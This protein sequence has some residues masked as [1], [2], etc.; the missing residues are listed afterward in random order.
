MDIKKFFRTIKT[1]IHLDDKLKSIDKENNK[2]QNNRYDIDKPQADI[3][4]ENNYCFL[5]KHLKPAICSI[6]GKL[7]DSFIHQ[8]FGLQDKPSEQSILIQCG[9]IF[10]KFNNK[11]ITLSPNVENLIE[12]SNYVSIDGKKRQVDHLFKTDNNIIWYL[13]SKCNL[14]FDTE[15]KPA[16]NEKINDLTKYFKDKY[17]GYEIKSGYLVLVLKQIPD[18]ILKKNMLKIMY[19]V[20]NGS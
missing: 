7:T 13:E 12:V 1:A 17:P 3:T 15:K 2:E 20:W 11:L 8:A 19:L 14:N 6:K 16:S 10:E 4:M 5:E 9:N 18:D